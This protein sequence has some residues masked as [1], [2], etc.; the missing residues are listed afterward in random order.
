MSEQPVPEGEDAT[1]VYDRQHGVPTTA[2]EQ[3]L[4]NLSEAANK[5]PPQDTPFKVTGK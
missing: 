1:D 3:R 2:D 5:P 4:V